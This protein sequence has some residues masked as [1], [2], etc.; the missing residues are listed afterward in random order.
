MNIAEFA[1]KVS[2]LQ[3]CDYQK[4]MLKRLAV[5]PE[6]SRIVMSRKGPILLDKDGKIITKEQLMRIRGSREK[7]LLL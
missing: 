3:L 5:L 4:E 2:G 1:E 6:G 7:L